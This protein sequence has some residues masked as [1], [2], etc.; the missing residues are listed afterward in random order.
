MKTLQIIGIV[1]LIMIAFIG[2]VRVILDTPKSFID[3]LT[4]MFLLDLLFDVVSILAKVIIE[5]FNND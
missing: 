2:I 5:I 4:Q 3:V 1:F